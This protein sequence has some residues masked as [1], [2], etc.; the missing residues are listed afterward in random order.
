[1][2]EVNPHHPVTEALHD[3]WHS[4]CMALL[5][6]LKEKEIVLT[7]QDIQAMCASGYTA[8]IAHEKHDGLHLILATKEEMAI[9]LRRSKQ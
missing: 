1:M 7:V 2:T 4:I 8:I 3:Q 5:L 6:R 9:W